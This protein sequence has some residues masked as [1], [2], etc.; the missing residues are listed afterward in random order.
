LDPS[1]HRFLVA[2]KWLRTVLWSLR[3]LVVLVILYQAIG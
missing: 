2:S 3:G 1:A